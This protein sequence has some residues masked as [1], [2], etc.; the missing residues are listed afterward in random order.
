[1]EKSWRSE[2]DHFMDAALKTTL[3]EKR[4]V[5]DWL[6]EPDELYST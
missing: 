2:N 3:M 6:G 1:M 5:R 4:L